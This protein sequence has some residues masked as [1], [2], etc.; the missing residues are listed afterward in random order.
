M[1]NWVVLIVFN[2]LSSIYKGIGIKE[3]VEVSFHVIKGDLAFEVVAIFLD[4]FNL[5][6]IEDLDSLVNSVLQLEVI[7]EL[8]LVLALDVQ[9]L[10]FIHHK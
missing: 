8:K 9:L 1:L 4:F 5:D 2:D 7:C 3:K 10:R 6:V